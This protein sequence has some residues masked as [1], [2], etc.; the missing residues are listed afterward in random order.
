MLENGTKVK[1]PILSTEISLIHSVC[2]PQL[3]QD[4]K[5]RPTGKDSKTI[6]QLLGELYADKE[7]LEKLWEETGEKNPHRSNPRKSH[8]TCSK[9]G[10]CFNRPPFWK[11]SF[12]N[13]CPSKAF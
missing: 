8:V 13:I 9:S 11:A 3:F 4:R 12:G 7:Y 5:D 1:S 2:L 6:K 10:T